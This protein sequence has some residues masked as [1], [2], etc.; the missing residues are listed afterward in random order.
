[1]PEGGDTLK[2]RALD[3]LEQVG[4]I[5][6]LREF[7]T[8]GI[9]PVILRRMLADGSISNPARGIYVLASCGDDP[10]LDYAVEAL[11]AP[12]TSRICLLSAAWLQSLIARDPRELFLGIPRQTWAPKSAGRLPVCPLPWKGLLPN[13]VM[14]RTQSG[15]DPSAE[16]QLSGRTFYITSPGRTVV[17]LI[18]FKE[19]IGLETAVE[20]LGSALAKGVSIGEIESFADQI[21]VSEEV[22]PFLAGAGT[23]FNRRY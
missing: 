13:G 11:S 14:E 12:P 3:Y 10:D 8:L 19:R 22:H 21:G 20:A 2:D 23:G 6:Q 7:A 5:A 4:G 16:I 17:D 15:L 18:M 9:A 1:M